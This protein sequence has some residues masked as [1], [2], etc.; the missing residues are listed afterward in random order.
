MPAD[1]SELDP[2]TRAYLE[3]R[4]GI[5]GKKRGWRWIALGISII[6]LPWLIW[7]A[8]HHSNPEIRYSIVSYRPIDSTAIEITFDISRRNPSTPMMCTVVAR[9]VDKNVVGELDLDIPGSAQSLIRQ[10]GVIPTRLA[11]VNAEVLRCMA[12]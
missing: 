6:G 11:A 12:R 1:F 3:D 5:R 8:W 2:Q 9:D 4:Y 10:S 7:S